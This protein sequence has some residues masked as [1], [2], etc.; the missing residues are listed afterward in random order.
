MF[1]PVDCFFLKM[2]S[3][4]YCQDLAA[5]LKGATCNSVR[6]FFFIAFFKICHG[7]RYVTLRTWAKDN[8]KEKGRYFRNA[9]LS[10]NNEIMEC[11]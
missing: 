6:R 3:D 8:G 4:A 5:D 11:V 9:V 1:F 7:E 10:V 2:T